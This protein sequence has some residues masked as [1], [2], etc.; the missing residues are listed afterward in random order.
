MIK[1]G[2]SVVH[3]PF[4][5]RV[6][7]IEKGRGQATIEGFINSNEILR[8]RVIDETSRDVRQVLIPVALLV[9][10]IE[11]GLVSASVTYHLCWIKLVSYSAFIIGGSGCLNSEENSITEE[12]KGGQLESLTASTPVANK[13]ESSWRKRMTREWKLMIDESRRLLEK[14]KVVSVKSCPW[15][16]PPLY[17]STKLTWAC[18]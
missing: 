18:T 2:Q 4:L 9:W 1:G 12:G 14:K 7:I 15:G 16:C 8:W 10:K 13:T 6:G 3:Q 11:V 17:T 5:G